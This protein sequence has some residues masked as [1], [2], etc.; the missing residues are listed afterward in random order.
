MLSIVEKSGHVFQVGNALVFIEKTEGDSVRLHID[1]PL[2]IDIHRDGLLAKILS[3]NDFVIDHKM[4]EED[5]IWSEWCV[6]TRTLQRCT[7]RAAL[8]KIG[9][10]K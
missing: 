1:A 3:E 5:G 4:R 9:V 10:I 8:T 6:N 7:L 2:S